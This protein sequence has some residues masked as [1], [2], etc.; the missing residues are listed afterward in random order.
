MATRDEPRVGN[1]I[2]G[3]WRLTSFTEANLDTGAVSYP[4]GVAARAFVIYDVNGYVATIF[5]AG[6]RKPPVTTQA[7]EQEAIQLYRQHDRLRWSL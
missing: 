2:A 5:S 4:F 6:D 1:P 3:T 7:T